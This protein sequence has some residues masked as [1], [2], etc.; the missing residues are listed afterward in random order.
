MDA[1]SPKTQAAARD[2]GERIHRAIQRAVRTST[3]AGWLKA[4][5]ARTP[6]LGERRRCLAMYDVMVARVGLR[7]EAVAGVAADASEEDGPRLFARLLRGADECDIARRS[8]FIQ[9]SLLGLDHVRDLADFSR[10]RADR[11]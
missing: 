11:H 2:R 4:L 6:D 8:A 9:A 7:M 1:T 3:V 10:L 5:A